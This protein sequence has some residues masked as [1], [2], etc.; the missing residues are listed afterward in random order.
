METEKV[1]IVD[2]FGH[3][4]V[5]KS[6]GTIGAEIYSAFKSA[7]FVYLKNHGIAAP[8]IE[9]AFNVSRE[10]FQLPVIV[11]Q[12]YARPTDSNEGW[13]A[14]ERESLNPERPADLKE[15]F[16]FSKKENVKNCLPKEV[17]TFNPVLADLFDEAQQLTFRVLEALDEGMPGNV[18][19]KIDN[20]FTN[21]HKLIG[22][23][24][25]ATGLRSLYYPALDPEG[26]IKPGQVR[27]GEH[28]DY[29]SIT[30][31]FQDDIGG[32]EVQRVDGMYVPAPPIPGTVLVNVGDLMQRWTAD[33]IKSTKH[34]VLIPEKELLMRQVRQSIAF[35]VQPDDNFL[36]TCL[37][38]S[39]KYEPVSSLDYLNMR[40]AATY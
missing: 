19:V 9:A 11:K 37:D 10:F 8:K 4:G 31:L 30:I 24:G 27:C 33:Q 28:S 21:S 22:K 1:P 14:V 6:L 23:P 15:A 26:S 29:G 38:G 17:T 36:I 39:N 18:N 20:I 32:L 25:N 16:N 13:V 5:M 34:R 35:F 12:K 2:F 3:D 7:G 40:F